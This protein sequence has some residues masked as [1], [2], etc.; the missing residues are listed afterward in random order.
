MDRAKYLERISVSEGELSPDIESLRRLQ[1]AHLLTV[2]FENLDIHWK[3]PIVLDVERFYHKVVVERRGGFCYELNGL[4]NELLISIGFTTRLIS[5]R[6]FNGK[7]FTPKFSHAAI[8][9]TIGEEEFLA[10]VGFGDF[11]SEPL[12]FAP[13]AEE[14]DPTADFVIRRYDEG[15]FEVAKRDSGSWKSEYLFKDEPHEL[16]DFA[17]MCDFQQYSPLSHFTKAKL[18]SI[19]TPTGRKTLTDTKF[20]VTD[21]SDRRETD[22]TGDDEFYSILLAE[23]GIKR[24]TE[25]QNT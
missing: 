7:E 11:T 17:E 14:I 5:A 3:R 6:V 22:V 2:P 23:F 20:I 19:M 9:V 18:I 4:F 15:L 8:I 1:R 10:D 21:G 25:H 16:S 24:P 12:S 13:E